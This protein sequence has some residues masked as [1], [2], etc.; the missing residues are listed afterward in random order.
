M[1]PRHTRKPC[2]CGSGLP[3]KRDL[4]LAGYARVFCDKCMRPV[5]HAR[6]YREIRD[7]DAKRQAAARRR[8]EE[9]REARDAE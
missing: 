1:S 9:M 8:L 4:S 7:E 5:E 6:T 3:G 2:P